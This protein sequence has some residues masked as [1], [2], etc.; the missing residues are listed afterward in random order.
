MV[1][2]M[3]ILTEYGDKSQLIILDTSDSG[4]VSR[5]CDEDQ[6]RMPML[7][8]PLH[9]RYCERCGVYIWLDMRMCKKCTEPNF[10]WTS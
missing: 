7:H 8:S 2:M 5:L 4:I 3:N 10:P 9:I 6:T 1:R